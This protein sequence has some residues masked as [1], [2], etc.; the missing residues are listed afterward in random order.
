[1][2]GGV[3][4]HEERA[5]RERAPDRGEEAALLASGAG[6]RLH[7][8]ARREPGELARLREDLLA[9]G[10]R[11]FENGHRRANDSV[12][13]SRI[14]L[15]RGGDAVSGSKSPGGGSISSSAFEMAGRFYCLAGIRAAAGGCASSE[16]GPAASSDDAG[17]DATVDGAAANDASGDD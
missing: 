13:H 11:D 8:D 12:L 14:L 4:G 1:A 9:R 10:Q 5:A 6:A 15:V 3:L 17:P 7:L 2:R 16:S